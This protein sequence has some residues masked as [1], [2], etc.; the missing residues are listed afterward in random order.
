MDGLRSHEVRQIINQR[1]DTTLQEIPGKNATRKSGGKGGGFEANIRIDS[2]T[3]NAEGVL[4]AREIIS[5]VID[6]IERAG[7]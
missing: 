5:K 7:N 3:K 2:L 1:I 6:V 4:R